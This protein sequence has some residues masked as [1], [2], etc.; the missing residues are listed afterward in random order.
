MK[1]TKQFVTEYN[2]NFLI[3]LGLRYSYTAFKSFKE[4]R[5]L[6]IKTK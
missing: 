4:K 2:I 1:T 5:L 6:T 3:N